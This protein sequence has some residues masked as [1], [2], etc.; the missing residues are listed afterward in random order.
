MVT[1]SFDFNGER[2]CGESISGFNFVPEVPTKLESNSFA[3]SDIGRPARFD[4]FFPNGTTR[5]FHG[6]QAVEINKRFRRAV[7]KE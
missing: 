6:D 5:S 2:F 3:M 1:W 7:F 4:F